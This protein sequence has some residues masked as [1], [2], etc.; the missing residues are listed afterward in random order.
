MIHITI[1]AKFIDNIIWKITIILNNI[2]SEYKKDNIRN[3]RST[4]R[5]VVN[6]SK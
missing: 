2:D 5:L 3:V 1:I 4:G 6:R